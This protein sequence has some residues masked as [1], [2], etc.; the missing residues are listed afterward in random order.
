MVTIL[1]F[2]IILFLNLCFESEVWWSNGAYIGDLKALFTRSLASLHLPLPF[3]R[4]GSQLPVPLR[5]LILGLGTDTGRAGLGCLRKGP[6]PR[7]CPHAQGSTGLTSEQWT[8]WQARQ[9]IMK[10]GKKS[11]FPDFW[12]RDLAFPFALISTNDMTSPRY[13]NYHHFTK[14]ETQ[15]VSV[16]CPRSHSCQLTELRCGLR[17]QRREDYEI[18]KSFS[19]G[20]RSPGSHF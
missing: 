2:L 8:A 16:I 9:E 13:Y 11:F 10:G 3:P 18:L 19:L 5:H 6:S 4:T 15:R 17:S 12:T 1:K 14:V 20:I 7:E